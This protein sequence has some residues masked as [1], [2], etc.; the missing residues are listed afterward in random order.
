MAA[1]RYGD[2]FGQR[3]R[4]YFAYT[5]GALVVGGAVIAGGIQ[6]G[7]FAG[8]GVNLFNVANFARNVIWSRRTVAHVPTPEGRARVARGQLQSVRVTRARGGVPVLQFDRKL[9]PGETLE[10]A[11]GMPWWRFD[12]SPRGRRRLMRGMTIEIPLADSAP[13]LSALLPAINAHGGSRKTVADAVQLLDTRGTYGLLHDLT[14]AGTTL[15]WYASETGQLA[16][17]PRELRLALEMAT[18]EDQER[19][20]MEGELAALEE[21]WREAEEIAA[22][23]DDMFLPRSIT[24]WVSHAHELPQDPAPVERGTIR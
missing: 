23:A 2:Q 22:I 18:H 17:F 8:A 9:S 1:W 16:R 24:D 7:L 10:T 20:A 13:A 11:S 6:V 19:A 14:T 5:A 4:K 12:G 15:R 21:R 3:R